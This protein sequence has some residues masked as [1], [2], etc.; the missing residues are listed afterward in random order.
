[1]N[2]RRASGRR[3]G[4]LDWRHA[5]RRRELLHAIGVA[6]AVVV[7]TILVIFVIKP[8]DSSSTPAPVQQTPASVPTGDS[9]SSGSTGATGGTG[10][11]GT[12]ATSATTPASTTATTAPAP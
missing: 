6:A 9:G 11:T 5:D 8:G 7:G 10:S 2:A 4:P 1:M 12:P 3:S